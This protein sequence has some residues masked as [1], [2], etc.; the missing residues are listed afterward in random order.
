MFHHKNISY[1]LDAIQKISDIVSS[2][3]LKRLNI[4][5]TFLYIDINVTPEHTLESLSYELYG[6]CKFWYV[7]QII[8][9]VVN[10]YLDMP[11][12]N[13]TLVSYCNAKYGNAYDLHWFID[14]RENTICDDRSTI[15][16]KEKWQDGTLPEYI[17]PVSHFEY[18]LEENA[19]KTKM[20]AVN[21]EFIYLFDEEYRKLIDAE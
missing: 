21:P 4:D 18:E 10:P 3:V 1:N 17:I 5:R 15:K 11:M 16:W 13:D 8:N 19:K 6:D 7:L 14:N 9:N 2:I 20:K 12:D